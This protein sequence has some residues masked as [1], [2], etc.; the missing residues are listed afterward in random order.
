[1]DLESF[2]YF[3][4]RTLFV[5]LAFLTFIDYLRYRD[6]VHLYTTLLLGTLAASFLLGYV[7]ELLPFTDLV[8]T[9]SWLALLI[10]PFIFLLLVRQFRS[11]HRLAQWL[12]LGG[13]VVSWALILLPPVYFP[14]WATLSI[15]LYFIGIEGYIITI[16]WRE[17]VRAQGV[18]RP[19][20]TLV[21]AASGL[22]VV[23]I[24]LFGLS[25]AWPQAQSVLTIL[26]LILG[27]VIAWGYYLGFVPP[28][29]L[30]RTWQLAEVHRFLEEV[31]TYPL[32]ERAL[33]VS[34]LLRQ[35]TMRVVETADAI[36]ACW[37]DRDELLIIDAS[38]P[39][40]SLA[41]Q[42]NNRAGLIGRIW[43]ERQ[44]IVLNGQEEL[45]RVEKQLLSDL[46]A[47]TLMG[48][49]VATSE[50]VWGIMLV[51]LVR[52]PL[53]E[54][55][56]MSLLTLLAQE[57]ANILAYTALLAEQHTLINR[58]NRREAA[59]Q[60]AHEQTQALAKV[61]THLNAQVGSGDS[62]S[63]ICETV[64][65]LF[66]V[67]VVTI[68]LYD[69][70]KK[71]LYL[72]YD[73]GLPDALRREF[74][75]LSRVLDD[76]YIELATPVTVTPD[77]QAVT[78]LPNHE[79]Y[80]RMGLRTTAN[81]PM[82]HGDLLI[83]RLNMG[84]IG[85]IRE[86]SEQELTLLKGIADQA[87][88][89]IHRAFLYHQVQEHAT[90]LEQRVAERT[91][92]LQARNQELDAFAHTVAHDLKSPLALITG[93]TNMLI[94]EYQQLHP[95]EGAKLLYYIS[96]SSG[97][98]VNIV[99][100]LLLLANT[101]REDISLER[102]DMAEIVSHVQ[103]RLAYMVQKYQATIVVPD[104][105]PQAMGYAPWLEEVWANYVSNAIKYG[106]RPPLVQ[107]GGDVQS[108]GMLRFWVRDNGPGI[109]LDKQERLF[110]PFARL[111]EEPVEGSH[112]LGLSIVERIITR[113]G[114]QVGCES[115]PGEGS[116]FYLT[117]PCVYE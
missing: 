78:E 58:L 82:W 96:Q 40:I 69:A 22:L 48:I 10:H 74:R 104:S 42:L 57:M 102:L 111:N 114:G 77:V 7:A 89:A 106:G 13:L 25:L 64:A 37:A 75:A 4:A 94:D 41:R 23:V 32:D 60:Q 2:L 29:W 79:L 117:L 52:R 19:R 43:S 17:A 68:S 116:L 86:F 39:V 88:I 27:I 83:G 1:M 110:V 98:M 14:M 93:F 36:I 47:N 63:V 80:L 73:F 15:P 54:T 51:F 107:L 71:S 5:L 35:T 105:W 28:A 113:L 12:A 8:S 67:P 53:F 103:E 90:Q 61:A 100:A 3:I 95:D 99:D 33:M 49:P 30:N 92:E 18:T 6:W 34:N 26:I 66:A 16:V 70:A 44:A 59:L 50:R 65:Q 84:T 38:P 46:K 91:A 56:D 62:F 55:A 24:I 115:Q 85:E 112:G 21:A 11:I 20:L 87:A 101:R 31:A 72:A 45:A 97:K 108:D 81:A 76:A 109:P 9:I